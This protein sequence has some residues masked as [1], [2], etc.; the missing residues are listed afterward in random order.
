MNVKQGREVVARYREH[1]KDVVPGSG[2]MDWTPSVQEQRHHAAY[3]LDNMDKFLNAIEYY[4]KEF[5]HLADSAWGD[6]ERTQEIW[7]KFN[8]WLGFLQGIFWSLGEFSLDDMRDHNRPKE[9]A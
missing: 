3:M 1:L 9:T 5:D 8:R 6:L 2:P 4:D 7:G